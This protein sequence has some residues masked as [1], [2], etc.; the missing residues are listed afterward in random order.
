M[1]SHF[2]YVCFNFSESDLTLTN[3]LS[4]YSETSVEIP[5][6]SIRNSQYNPS[7]QIPQTNYI[8]RTESSPFA[9]LKAVISIQKSFNFQQQSMQKQ[10]RFEFDEDK[11]KQ[12]IDFSDGIADSVSYSSS[13]IQAKQRNFGSGI[14][15]PAPKLVHGIF[16]SSYFTHQK[17]IMPVSFPPQLLQRRAV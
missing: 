1:P 10:R 11:N 2:S 15:T 4:Q 3:R 12:C 14:L 6:L 16:E 7:I 13:S 17:P 5:I 8:H 9:T